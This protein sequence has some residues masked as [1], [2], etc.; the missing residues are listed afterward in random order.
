[1]K[2]PIAKAR[3]EFLDSDVGKQLYEPR[4]INCCPGLKPYL[5]NRVERAYLQGWEDCE[6]ERKKRG[7][8]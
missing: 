2:S 1:M 5:K 7:R 4:I 3:D 8:R 6:N